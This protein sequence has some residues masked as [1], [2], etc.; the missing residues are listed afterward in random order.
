[1][2]S[3]DGTSRSLPDISAL[4][5]HRIGPTV[6]I[7]CMELV[8]LVLTV[9]AIENGNPMRA[10][11]AS[12]FGLLMLCALVFGWNYRHSHATG[13]DAIRHVQR[14]TVHYNPLLFRLMVVIFGC[15]LVCALL[16]C[17]GARGLAL[18][19]VGAAA[20][21]FAGFLWSALVTRT[22][23]NGFIEL[24]HDGIHHRGWAFDVRVRWDEIFGVRM[25]SGRF[26]S[27]VVTMGEYAKPDNRYTTRLY[28]VEHLWTKH[29]MLV[30]DCR[31]IHIHPLALLEWIR[32]YVDHPAARVEL[33]TEAAANRLASYR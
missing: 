21:H 9:D 13:A 25:T 30:F 22:V 23:R 5:R 6:L 2:H 27:V 17:A 11:R 29:Q 24:D 28:R 18:V 33:G 12:S 31:A 20:V 26:P 16:F 15:L 32:F 7:V 1:M 4:D 3:S 8:V 10:A 14:S 19:L